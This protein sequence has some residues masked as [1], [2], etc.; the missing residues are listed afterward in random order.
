MDSIVLPIWAFYLTVSWTFLLCVI[1]Q[2]LKSSHRKDVVM[3]QKKF[4]P[5]AAE[6]KSGPD[7]FTHLGNLVFIPSDKDILLCNHNHQN[8][9]IITDT[10]QPLTPQSPSASCQ[11]SQE[12]P[13]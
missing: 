5:W 9:E 11:L 10:W 7:A 13:S 6:S 12:H 3:V 8:Q 4:F 1:L 2:V